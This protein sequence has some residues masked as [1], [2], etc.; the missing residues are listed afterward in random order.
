MNNTNSTQEKYKLFNEVF[1][2]CEKACSLQADHW[3]AFFLRSMLHSLMNSNA[4]DE[5]AA[6]L[7]TSEYTAAEAENECLKM[8]ELQKKARN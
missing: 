6:Y 8:I 4:V 2:S 3:P 1:K 5:M 7:L